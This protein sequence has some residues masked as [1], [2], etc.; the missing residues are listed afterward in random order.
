M[1][2]VQVHTV[3]P[4]SSCKAKSMLLSKSILH[5]HVRATCPCLCKSMSMLHV[6]VHAASPCPCCMSM[7]MLQYMSMLQSISMLQHMSMLYIY[8]FPCCIPHV[9]AACPIVRIRAACPCPCRMSMSTQN[10]EKGTNTNMVTIMVMDTDMGA[11]TDIDMDMNR[12]MDTDR[13]EWKRIFWSDSK[14]IDANISLHY[15]CFAS[16]GVSFGWTKT[17]KLAVSLFRETTKTNLL[18]LNSVKISFGSFDMNRVSYDTLLPSLS[19]IVKWYNMY[20][21]CRTITLMSTKIIHNRSRIVTLT[22]FS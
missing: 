7:S 12:D 11:D 8:S 2:H 9:Q 14:Q 20:V 19:S 5:A 1:L 15:S 3:C 13:D 22:R 17:P 16:K 18:V 21:K 6:H 4:C 10:V